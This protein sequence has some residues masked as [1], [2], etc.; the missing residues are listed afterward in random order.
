MRFKPLDPIFNAPV[1]L[2]VMSVLISVEKASFGYLKEATE[3]TQ[4]NLSQQI[5]KLKDA[6][7]IDVIKSFENNYPKTECKIT[8]RGRLAFAKYVEAL[9]TYIDKPETENEIDTTP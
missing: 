8:E 4:G 5:K 6:E 3:T 9:A 1:R 2:G 7:Y